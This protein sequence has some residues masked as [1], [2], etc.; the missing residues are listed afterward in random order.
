MSDERTIALSEQAELQL[1]LGFLL[2]EPMPADDHMEIAVATSAPA[3]RHKL[4]ESALP[5]AEK[6]NP[7]SRKTDLADSAQVRLA[8]P[9]V[10]SD[11]KGLRPLQYSKACFLHRSGQRLSHSTDRLCSVGSYYLYK[12][13]ASRPM[14]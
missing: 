3:N 14:N 2:I 9:P 6:F 8:F 13:P 11:L 5:T 7:E 12:M 4:P 1:R 10:K